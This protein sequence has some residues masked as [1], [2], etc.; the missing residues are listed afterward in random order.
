MKKAYVHIHRFEYVWVD[1]KTEHDIRKLD[2][3]QLMVDQIWEFDLIDIP[4]DLEEDGNVLDLTYVENKVS[5]T[6]LALIEWS[7]KESTSIKDRFQSILANANV[8]L[9][10]KG[11]RLKPF[12]SRSDDDIIGHVG[13]ILDIRMK[14]KQDSSTPIKAPKLKFTI[15]ARKVKAQGKPLASNVHETWES[16]VQDEQL[17][18][19]HPWIL[20]MFIN[21]KVIRRTM[22]SMMNKEYHKQISPKN[23]Y[24]RYLFLLL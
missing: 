12:S 21:F 5:S 11:I 1:C 14:N 4:H 20:L 24:P 23:P 22:K 16:E 8:W 15:W 3:C 9:S 7:Q 13:R 2:Y 10:S 17:E 18:G 6:P 19:E